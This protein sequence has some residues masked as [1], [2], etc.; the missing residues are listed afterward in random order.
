LLNSA[1]LDVKVSYERIMHRKFSLMNV[2]IVETT[3]GLSPQTIRGLILESPSHFL[4][5]RCQF[6]T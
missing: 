4:N 3:L 1:A 6:V 5:S 2:F